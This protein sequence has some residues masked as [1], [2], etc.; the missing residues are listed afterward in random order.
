MSVKTIQSRYGYVRNE[1][2]RFV[3]SAKY[4][5]DYIL[6]DAVGKKEVMKSFDAGMKEVGY[7]AKDLASNYFGYAQDIGVFLVDDI[8]NS[9][10][11]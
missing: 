1:I 6:E 4:Q 7:L 2:Q 8:R 10:L 9:V 5:L 3:E 11:A